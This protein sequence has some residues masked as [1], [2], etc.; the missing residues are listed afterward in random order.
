MIT[1]KFPQL[2]AGLAISDEASA[3]DQAARYA[4][5]HGA[6]GQFT[7]AS[8]LARRL[9]ETISRK[10]VGRAALAMLSEGLQDF[11][12]LKGDRFCKKTGA[13]FVSKEEAERHAL[14]VVGVNPRVDQLSDSLADSRLQG[15]KQR[16][17]E[18]ETDA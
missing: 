3:A 17:L 14:S 6:Q 9:Y 10:F 7:P 2:L 12:V 18:R 4:I 8:E 15:W 1:S 13:I 16:N 5:F 11:A